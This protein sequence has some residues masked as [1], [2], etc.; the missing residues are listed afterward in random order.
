[1]TVY[2]FQDKYPTR[3]EREEVLKTMTNHEI[4]EIIESCTV[5]QGK[6][7]YSKFKTKEQQK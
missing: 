1:M 4:D 6:I 3:E 5:V 2:E 7:Y